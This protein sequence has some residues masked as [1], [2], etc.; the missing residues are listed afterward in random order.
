M[1]WLIILAAI[2]YGVGAFKFWKGFKSTNFSQNR[3]F[4]TA[5]WPVLIFNGAYRQNFTRALKG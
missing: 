4:L 3:F 1:P 2:A 5:A